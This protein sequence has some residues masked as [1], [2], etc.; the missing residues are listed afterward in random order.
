[1]REGDWI[2]CGLLASL[3]VLALVIS[4]TKPTQAQIEAAA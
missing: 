1:M 2:V 4:M 3:I